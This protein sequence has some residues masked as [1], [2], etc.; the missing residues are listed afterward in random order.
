[1]QKNTDHS[2][3]TMQKDYFVFFITQFH[4]R[5][6]EDLVRSSITQ[7]RLK[8]H[9][10][11]VYVELTQEDVGNHYHKYH[12]Y[13]YDHVTSSCASYNCLDFLISGHTTRKQ[14][15]LDLCGLTRVLSILPFL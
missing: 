14:M 12:K 5:H 10:R 13:V 9:E 6:H 15:V 3:T 8:H 4:L 1:M 2:F 11:L 7:F